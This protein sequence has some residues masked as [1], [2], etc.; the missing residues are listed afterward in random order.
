[1]HHA[2]TLGLHIIAGGVGQPKSSFERL[3]SRE[4]LVCAFA[5]KCDSKAVL[6]NPLRNEISAETR[7]NDRRLERFNNVNDRL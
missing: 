6:V 2:E 5:T 7:P 1:M 3:V 4:Q